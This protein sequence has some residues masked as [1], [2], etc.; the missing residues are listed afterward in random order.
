MEKVL[1]WLA[2]IWLGLI[3]GGCYALS[4][5]LPPEGQDVVGS[6]V[7][8][9][10]RYEDT[11]SDFARDYD[12]GYRE[13]RAANPGVDPWLPGAGTPGFLQPESSRGGVLRG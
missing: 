7:E 1:I 2:G 9:T 6:P 5:P 4:F 3:S 11:F 13:M 12:L 8:I 10:S